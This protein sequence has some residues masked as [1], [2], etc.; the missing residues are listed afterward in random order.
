MRIAAMPFEHP[1]LDAEATKLMGEPTLPPLVGDWTTTTGVVA[2]ARV[3][4]ARI[5][6][7]ERRTWKMFFRPDM[8]LLFSP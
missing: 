3:A 6:E 1:E 7:P 4:D 2:N 5:A 8:I